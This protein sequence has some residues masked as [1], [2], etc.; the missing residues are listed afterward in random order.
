MTRTP[1]SWLLV[2]SER[3]ALAWVLREQRMAFTAQRRNDARRLAQGHRLFVYATRGCFHNPTRDRGRI[4]GEAT[5]VSAITDLSSP[6]ELSGRTF[7]VGCGLRIPK[8][9]IAQLSDGV[10][11]APLVPQLRTFPDPAS[12]SAR[13][14]QPLLLLADEDAPV[15]AERLARL[16]RP[17]DVVLAE[18]VAAASRTVAAVIGDR[19]VRAPSATAARSRAR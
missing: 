10:E 4:I 2:I 16:V 14:R 11:L 15:I 3:E 18:Y 17:R 9:K 1:T 13:I 5:V 12:W 8:P 6:L 7:T 19:D